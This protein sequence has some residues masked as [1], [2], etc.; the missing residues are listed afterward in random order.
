MKKTLYIIIPLILMGYLIVIT[1]IPRSKP[2]RFEVEKKISNYQS[3]EIKNQSVPPDH[4]NQALNCKSCHVCEYPT[5]E[6]PCLLECPRESMVSVFHSFEEG[7]EVV[8]IDEMSENY[9]GVVFSHKLHTHMSEMSAGCTGCHHYNTTGPVLNCRKC[10]ENTRIRENVSLP[11]LKAAYHRQC[12]ACHKQWSL[13]NGCNTQCHLRKGPDSQVHLQQLIKEISV[14]SHPTRPEPTKMIWET[15]NVDG[16]IVTF[17]H[18]EHARLFNLKCSDCHSSDNCSKCHES[19]TSKD[20]SKTIKTT[21]STEEHHKP[22]SSCHNINACQKCHKQNEM[23]PFNH[24]RASGWN[25]KGYHSSIT[26]AKCHG[27]KMP[28]RKLDNDCVSCH[29]NFTTGSF[30]HKVIG[31]ILSENHSELECNN[32][33]ADENFAKAPVCSE[34]HDDKS[35]PADLPGKKK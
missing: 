32:C 25:L 18:D 19:K 9:M 31:L 22:C 10:H 29:K 23:M 21:K 3:E 14:K 5:K 20:F 12:M 34:C 17:F 7:P 6:D 33:H 8:V 1:L 27:N 24:G 35:Y 30:N 11:D 2:Q 13:E 4:V 28:F 26:C 15:N 16:K